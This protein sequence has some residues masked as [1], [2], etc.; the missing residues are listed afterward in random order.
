MRLLITGPSGFIGRHTVAAAAAAGHDVVPWSRDAGWFD[1]PRARSAVAGVD[2]IIHLAGSYLKRD[3][4]PLTM[5]DAFQANVAPTAVLLDACGRADV[6]RVVLASSAAVYNPSAMLVQGETCSTPGRTPY[7]A[8]KLCAEALV[9]AHG[10]ISL[11]LFNVYGPGQNVN[12]VVHTIARQALDA[13]PVRILDD[14]PVRDFVHVA[15]VARALVIA[16]TRP[17]SLPDAVNIGTGQGTSIRDLAQVILDAA[18]T[19]GPV[20][21]GNRDEVAVNSFVADITLACKALDF[22]FRFALAEGVQDTLAG[23]HRTVD[24]NP[25]HSE[26]LHEQ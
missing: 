3:G 26:N 11:R 14:R 21:P 19:A 7:S 1:Q 17:G 5:L 10:G 18:G 16:A 6:R 25:I 12:N 9:R 24:C 13:V 20:L 15:D 8:S 23:M 2:A 22:R 4:G